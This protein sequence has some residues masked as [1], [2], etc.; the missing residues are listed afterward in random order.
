[1]TRQ[2]GFSL[3]VKALIRD[4]AEGCCEVCGEWYS[5]MQH[6]HRRPRGMGG[7]R[8]LDTNTPSGCLLLC[9]SCHRHVESH[10]SLAYDNGWLVPQGQTPTD[11]PVLRRG[12]L[13]YLDDLGGFTPV[14]SEAVG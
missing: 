9:G 13:V 5:A 14:A 11:V 3:V 8:R 7:T 2:T 4:R 1:V 12:Q 10:R 6:H